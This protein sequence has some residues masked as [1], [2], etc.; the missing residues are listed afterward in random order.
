MFFNRKGRHGVLGNNGV[1]SVTEGQGLTVSELNASVT[2]VAVSVSAVVIVNA[3]KSEVRPV[4]QTITGFGYVNVESEGT[5][6]LIKLNGNGI[7][8]TA[9]E[10]LDIICG[11]SKRVTG[12]YVLNLVANHLNACGENNEVINYRNLNLKRCSQ[13]R[14]IL[15]GCNKCIFTEPE[16]LVAFLAADDLNVIEAA[17]NS[18]LGAVVKSSKNGNCNLVESL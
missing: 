11:I 18:D 2:Y 4:C 13:R 12:E 6:V 3:L 16:G 10:E 14:I 7:N 9:I 1:S 15:H 8:C 17:V 5:I